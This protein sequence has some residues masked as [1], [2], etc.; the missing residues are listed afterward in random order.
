MVFA[1]V[2]IALNSVIARRGNMAPESRLL[3][4]AARGAPETSEWHLSIAAIDKTP[5]KVQLLSITGEDNVESNGGI[6]E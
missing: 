3:K 6:D 2:P 5:Y 4:C 1:S